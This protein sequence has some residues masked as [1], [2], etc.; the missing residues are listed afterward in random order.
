MRVYSLDTETMLQ[1][2]RERRQTGILATDLP[3]GTAGT[4]GRLRAIV[5]ITAGKII[6]CRIEESNGQLWVVGEE[7]LQE[8]HRLGTLDWSLTLQQTNPKLPAIQ[9]TSPTLDTSP[10]LQNAPTP[11]TGPIRR[12]EP[13]I[14]LRS[15]QVEVSQM[16][17]WPRTHRMVYA[18][19]D[20]KNTTKRI[21]ELLSLQTTTLEQIL[22]DL[23]NMRVITMNQ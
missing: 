22:R 10:Y 23:Q 7:A 1:L 19:I 14:P 18:M 16:T 17:Q 21:A 4:R 8:L 3:M 13:Q 5:T 11:I 2:L 12:D 20:G 15:M 6:D 9:Q